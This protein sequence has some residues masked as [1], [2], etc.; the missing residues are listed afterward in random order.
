MPSLL[1]SLE[2][3]IGERLLQARAEMPPSTSF[4][5]W[6]LVWLFT[7]ALGVLLTTCGVVK[8]RQMLYKMQLVAKVERD[9]RTDDDDEYDYDSDEKED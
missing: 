7:T 4:E 6:S 1:W 2:K 9:S 5:I 3:R 8:T